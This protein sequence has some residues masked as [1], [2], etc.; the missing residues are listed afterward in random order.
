M[1]EIVFTVERDEDSSVLVAAWDDPS[2]GGIT[3]QGEDLRELEAMVKDAVQCYFD[4]AEWPRTIR[5]HFLSDP[6]LATA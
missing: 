3:T 6:V 5:L 4:E 1:N 2:G